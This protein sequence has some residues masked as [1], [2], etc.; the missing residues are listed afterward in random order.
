[1]STLLTSEEF[2]LRFSRSKKANTDDV[3]YDEAHNNNGVCPDSQENDEPGTHFDQLSE[4]D[5][6]ED[7]N[8]Y[9][10]EAARR[11][12]EQVYV[13]AGR[14]APSSYVESIASYIEDMFQQL[15]LQ[16]C[17]L[18]QGWMDVAVSDGIMY[19]SRNILSHQ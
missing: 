17:Q 2:D 4:R 18:R 8:G 14:Y 3:L 10:D 9:L 5:L 12:D 7:L 1:M 19:I 15:Q 16:V 13:A 11:E 6:G